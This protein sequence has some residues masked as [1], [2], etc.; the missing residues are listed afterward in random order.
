MSGQSILGIICVVWVFVLGGFLFISAWRDNKD[1]KA[2]DERI[3]RLLSDM[4]SR[5]NRSVKN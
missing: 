2:I 5:R 4:E 1:Y 3:D